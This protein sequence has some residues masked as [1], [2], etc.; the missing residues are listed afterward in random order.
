M[1]ATQGSISNHSQCQVMVI[2]VVGDVHLQ[3]MLGGDG[4]P[5]RQWMTS[6]SIL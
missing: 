2:V 1:A 3:S 6:K 5:F 4:F